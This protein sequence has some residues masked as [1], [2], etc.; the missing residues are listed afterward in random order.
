MKKH[1]IKNYEKLYQIKELLDTHDSNYFTIIKIN[2]KE[3]DEHTVSIVMTACNRSVQTYFTINTITKSSY[4]NIQVILVDDSTTD[5]VTIEKL[6]EYGIHIELIN[7]KNKFWINP[8]VNYNIGFMHVKGGKIII[9][10]AEVCHVGD[11]INYVVNN[12][13]DNEYHAMDVCAS[14]NMDTNYE[15]YNIHEMN[16]SHYNEIRRLCI[17]FWYQHSIHRNEYFH[18]LVAMTKKSFDKIGGFD[19]DYSLGIE[20]DDNA[21]VFEIKNNGIELINPSQYN[22]IMGV[23]QWHSQSAA[24]SYSNNINNRD[25]HNYKINYYNINKTF[26]KLTSYD[27][28]DVVSVINKLPE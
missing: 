28:K 13:K 20:Y 26:L 7:I 21:L 25:L 10:N 23:H 18:F 4:K 3:L 12:V 6:Q 14:Q 22:Q 1:L 5:P 9:Q 24:G 17:D 8:G 27:K 19:I 16:Y 11:V 2:E 15:L